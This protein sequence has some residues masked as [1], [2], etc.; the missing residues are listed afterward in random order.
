MLGSPNNNNI[1]MVGVVALIQPDNTPSASL[2]FVANLPFHYQHLHTLMANQRVRQLNASL[3]IKKKH[4]NWKMR[5][6]RQ[7]KQNHV[8]INLIERNIV[9]IHAEETHQIQ[10]L[11]PTI[12]ASKS[13]LFKGVG[14]CKQKEPRESRL[15]TFSRY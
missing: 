2:L 14:T 12:A 1:N 11:D 8:R 3:T 9:H 7:P 13:I 15:L 4:S 6:F 10:R 5:R